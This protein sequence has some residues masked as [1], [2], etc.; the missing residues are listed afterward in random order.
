MVHLD[1]RDRL[2]YLVFLDGL[3]L[4]A[5]WWWSLLVEGQMKEVLI[6]SQFLR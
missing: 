1:L 6:H 4:L 3:A 5:H 2:D